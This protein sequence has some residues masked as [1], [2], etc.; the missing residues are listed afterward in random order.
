MHCRAVNQFSA[1]SQ[2][3]NSYSSIVSQHTEEFMSTSRPLHDCYET[4]MST[5]L[6]HVLHYSAIASGNSQ[7]WYPACLVTM[8]VPCSTNME[9]VEPCTQA[10]SL[11]QVFV[12]CSTNME[13]VRPCT[14]AFSLGQ[15]FVPCSTNMG[16][17][18]YVG[19]LTQR[20]SLSV[21]INFV[22]S[23]HPSQW[24]VTYSPSWRN[25][26]SHTLAFPGR[27]WSSRAVLWT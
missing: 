24:L 14:Q 9:T 26:H 8:F 23:P 1:I 18:L 3:L 25:H 17:A 22:P 19:L 11:D 20:L 12:P 27:R 16:L 6:F 5:K 21:V 2:T 7:A 15:V 4:G 13:T 10:F